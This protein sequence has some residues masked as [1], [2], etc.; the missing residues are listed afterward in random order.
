MHTDGDR[1]ARLVYPLAMDYLPPSS[2]R[3]LLLI[4]VIILQA[5]YLETNKS[6]RRQYGARIRF[7]ESKQPQ[8]ILDYALDG[9]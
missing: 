9:D 8:E 4:R 2:A 6:I 5:I 3:L 7:T 1:L